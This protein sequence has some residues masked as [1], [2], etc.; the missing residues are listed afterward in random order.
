[1]QPILLLIIVFVIVIGVRLAIRGGLSAV[2]RKYRAFGAILFIA[3][4]L[5]ARYYVPTRDPVRRRT[6]GTI[7][8]VVLVTTGLIFVG[9]DLRRRRAG[10]KIAEWA[11][12]H[13]FTVVSESRSPASATLP[14]SLRQLPLL[15]SGQEP[16]TFFMVESEDGTHKVQTMVF[17]YIVSRVEWSTAAMGPRDRPLTMTVFAFRHP[18]RQ[19]PAFS[20]RPTFLANEAPGD[21][22]GERTIELTGQPRFAERFTL[23]GRHPAEI[24]SVFSDALVSALE[25]EPLWCLESSGEWCIAYHY[26]Q[27]RTFWTFRPSG[28]EYCTNPDQLAARLA[29]ARHLL[30]LIGAP[31]R[32]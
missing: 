13:G 3:L 17:G 10:W 18:T 11:A 15:R 7:M 16:E 28:F 5:A 4:A 29:T 9:T 31:V 32:R 6:E 12:M 2:P 25:R 24:K 27:A 19:L 21:E 30:G 14:E 26:Y 23:R 22:T 20:L 8:L 1:M